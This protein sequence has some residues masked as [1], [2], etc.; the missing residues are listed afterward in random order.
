MSARPTAH[1]RLQ[2]AADLVASCLREN[3]GAHAIITRLVREYGATYKR[4]AS[5]NTLRI[6][7]CQATCTWSDGQGLLDAWRRNATIK[8]MHLAGTASA[9]RERVS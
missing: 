1:E 7:G 8:L 6:A 3:A 9:E 2:S 5:T 4:E